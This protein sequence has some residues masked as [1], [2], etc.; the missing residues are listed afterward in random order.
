MKCVQPI[1][2]SYNQLPLTRM[3]TSQIVCLVLEMNKA[4]LADGEQT[5]RFADLYHSANRTPTSTCDVALL[6]L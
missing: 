2:V 4:K 6:H 5:I 1:S 3:S